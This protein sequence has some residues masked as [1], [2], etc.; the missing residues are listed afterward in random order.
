MENHNKI[1]NKIIF[2]VKEFAKIWKKIENNDNFALLR[3]GDGE[4][5]IMTGKKVTAQEGWQSPSEIGELGKALLNTLNIENENFIYGISCPCCDREAYYWYSTRIKSKNKTFANIF[6]NK[7]YPEFIKN[8]EKLKRDAIFIGN[9]R[10]KGKKIGNLNILKYYEISD[11]CFEFWENDAQKLVQNIENDFGNK[12]NLLYV[13]SAGPL[14]EPLITELWKNNPNN[15]YIDFGS[16]LDKYIH[17]K[18]TRPYENPNSKYGRRNCEMDNPETTNF[19]VSVVLT[20]YKRPENLKLQLD[21]IKNQTLKPKEILL[22]Q[23]GTGDTIKIPEEI[24]NEFDLIEI[25][26]E[27]KGVWE[28]FRIALKNA[29]SEYVCLFDDDTIPGESWLENCHSNFLKQEGIYGTIGI[30]CKKPEN[31]PHNDYI[32]L[33]WA[34]ELRETKEVDFV[35]H[36]WFLKKEWLECM[37]DRT[38]KYQRYKIAGED[39]TLSA[40]VKQKLGIKTFVPPHPTRHHNLWGSKK[41]LAIK[42]GTN[43]VSI[44]MQSPNVNS[45]NDIINDLIKDDY[46]FLSRTNPQYVEKMF[47]GFRL[48][49]LFSKYIPNKK[50]RHFVRG[51]LREFYYS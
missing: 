46:S 2:L 28:R 37:F 11:N 19:D 43:K 22:Y 51:K 6:V 26:P 44:S 15:C 31:Y 7:N 34:G 9:Y 36:S 38:E 1:N 4:R 27:N 50:F 17:E 48:S 12:N 30:L 21:A 5:A 45:M 40:T 16:C 8:F 10:A 3:Y 39:M 32:R 14:S 18:T 29:K 35:G 47:K 42:L 33:G 41:E 25:S 20:L 24:K 13:F 49:N 23:D